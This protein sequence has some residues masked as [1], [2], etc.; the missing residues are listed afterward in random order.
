MPFIPDTSRNEQR[1]KYMASEGNLTNLERWFVNNTGDG[2]RNNQLYK[3]GVACLDM[4]YAIQDT[5]AAV[6]ELNSKL[7]DAITLSELTKTIFKS[8]DAKAKSLGI[9]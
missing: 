4:G 2:N 9:V 7:K 8:L 3:F 1:Q 6:A 5:K